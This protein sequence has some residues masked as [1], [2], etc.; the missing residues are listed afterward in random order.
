MVRFGLRSFEPSIL[1]DRYSALLSSSRVLDSV[2][3]AGELL[4]GFW[5]LVLCFGFCLA[6]EVSSK[7]HFP[8]LETEFFVTGRSEKSL[9]WE[10]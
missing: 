7:H 9:P 2:S 4:C 5:F 8:P 1:G 6:W 3:R 10:F